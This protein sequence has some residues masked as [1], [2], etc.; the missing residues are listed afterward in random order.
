MT[1]THVAALGFIQKK[2]KDFVRSGVSNESSDQVK[3]HTVHAL[4]VPNA[5]QMTTASAVDVPLH[6]R[7]CCCR[8]WSIF[9]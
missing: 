4:H 6:S 9:H 5:Q 8:C 3:S 7:R 2:D 1:S